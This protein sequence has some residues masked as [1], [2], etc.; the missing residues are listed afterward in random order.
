MGSW[1]SWV[2]GG[3]TSVF[4]EGV[5]GSFFSELGGCC[6]WVFKCALWLLAGFDLWVQWCI[7]SLGLWCAKLVQ[8]CFCWCVAFGVGISGFLVSGFDGRDLPNFTG[9]AFWCL[10]FWFSDGEIRTSYRLLKL[11]LAAGFTGVDGGV[12]VV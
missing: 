2:L 7:K 1:W 10:E 4:S 3:F 6:R 9:L 5:R 12:F 8:W 11:V